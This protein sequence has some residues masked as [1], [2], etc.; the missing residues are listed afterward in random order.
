MTREIPAPLR[1][2]AGLAAAAVEEARKLPSRLASLPVVAV[3]TALQA[4]MRVQQRYADLVGRGDQVLAGL[5]EPDEQPPW[6]RF[7]EDE[8]NPNGRTAAY[9]PDDG[10]WAFAD[11]E[12]GTLAD[13]ADEY[14]EYV[15]DTA[16][17]EPPAPGPAR[18]TPSDAAGADRASEPPADPPARSGGSKAQQSMH[19]ARPAGRR[20]GG[21]KST[22]AGPTGAKTSKP[23]TAAVRSAA[24]RSV[25]GRSAA[26]GGDTASAAPPVTPVA[27][28]GKRASAAA[29]AGGGRAA[30]A[31]AA[32]PAESDPT[33][34]P[35]YDRLTLAQVRA[36]LTKLSADDLAALLEHERTHAGR[37][38]YLTML[39][40]RLNR[41][42]QR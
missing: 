24:G 18:I 3:S 4:S 25:A 13:D 9:R 5:R 35:N 23:K 12:I 31:G 8:A 11:E 29:K 39:E 19:P 15:A 40:N 32:H 27:A 41:T 16:P 7:D 14:D 17:G 30:T 26:A 33:P 21:G 2:A 1:A 42:H 10:G 28:G 38:P 37:A 36:R 6:A 34:L 22:G 20:S